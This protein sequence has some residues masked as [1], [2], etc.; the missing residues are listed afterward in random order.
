MHNK[1]LS[2]F[3][4]GLA[5]ASLRTVNWLRG[6][7]GADPSGSTHGLQAE[8]IDDG[9]NLGQRF[10]ANIAD[11]SIAHPETALCELLK[12]RSVYSERSSGENL[13][14]YVLA[15]VS[16]SSQAGDIPP[17]IESG[18]TGVR[19]YLTYMEKLILKP[20]SDSRLV[21]SRIDSYWDPI[22]NRSKRE[23]RRFICFFDKRELL[24][25]TV[26]P[27]AHA[28]IFFVWKCGKRAERRSES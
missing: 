23:Y 6:S 15:L 12:G 19:R 11:T 3:E 18:L 7:V 27:S 21:S 24:R 8:V 20:V 26:R 22:F 10:A 9:C 28:D 17:L 16:V 2:R 4:I 25:Y 1:Q 14:P 5:N 13:V